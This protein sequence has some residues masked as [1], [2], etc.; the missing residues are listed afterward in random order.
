ML[1]TPLEQFQIISIFSIKLLC[2]DFSFTNLSLI[3]VL[4]LIF[5]SAIVFFSSK[6]NSF[7]L[8]SY[9]YIGTLY[10]IFGTLEFN[11]C[12]KKNGISKFRYYI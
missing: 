1:L 3:S 12:K 5:L 8:L 2:L 10:I 11:Y 4:V 9:K 6:S 7:F